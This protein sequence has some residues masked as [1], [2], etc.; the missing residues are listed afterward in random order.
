MFT[1]EEIKIYKKL[2][3]P[4]KIQDFINS[5]K[6]NFELKG[7][8]CY[9][10]RKVLKH[11][12]AHCVE[13]AVLAASIL[14]FH[15]YPPL[16]IDLEATKDDYDHVLAVFKKDGFW[17]AITKANHACLRYR[18]PVYKNIRELAMSCFHEYFLNKN[19]KKTLRKYSI[20]VNLNRFN[21]LN[22]ET[23]EEDIWFVPEYLCDVKHFNILTKKQIR[24]LRKVDKIEIDSGKIVIE[25]DPL[26]RDSLG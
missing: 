11:K 8:T 7:D 15:G 18:E 13:A 23:S 1:K 24:G 10:P 20:P 14:K 21:K 3:T 17:G 9:S 5:L 2:K 26:G 16:I 22:W 19:G 12:K 4:A 6:T 25:K